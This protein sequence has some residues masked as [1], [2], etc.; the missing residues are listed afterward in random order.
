M[1]KPRANAKESPLVGVW[2][3]RGDFGSQVEYHVQKKGSGYSVSARDS[4]DGELA[5]VFEEKWDAVACILTF[6][7][8]WNSTGRFARC[9][10][11]LTAKDQVDLTYTFTDTESLI[12]KTED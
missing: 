12:R 9:R 10:L 1:P 3:S 5:D 4:S 2:R 6:A 11:Q 8:H 7:V